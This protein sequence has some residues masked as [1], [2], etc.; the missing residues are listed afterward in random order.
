MQKV[1]KSKTFLRAHFWSNY[2]Q[3]FLDDA[4][5]AKFC[6]ICFYLSKQSNIGYIFWIFLWKIMKG[7][8]ENYEIQTTYSSWHVQKNT[9]K[10]QK[11]PGTPSLWI[12]HLKYTNISHLSLDRCWDIWNWSFWWPF[13]S[14]P[15]VWQIHWSQHVR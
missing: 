8:S 6:A 3:T 15:T 11:S 13:N 4:K 1:S 7:W 9:R 2:V 10:W 5:L 14:S 12:L